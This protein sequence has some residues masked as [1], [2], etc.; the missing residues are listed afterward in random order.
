MQRESVWA[1]SH[2]A[3]EVR[4]Q[5]CGDIAVVCLKCSRLVFDSQLLQKYQMMPDCARHGG[6][7]PVGDSKLFGGLLHDAGQRSI[8]GVAD[9]RAQMMD[10]VMV[11]TAREP[12][13][14]RIRRRV[15]GC[16]REDVI[17]AVV[18]VAA[19]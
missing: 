15:I 12:A 4:A 8:V 10:D 16:G 18:E 2:L 6:M 13:H 3:P 9:K 19:A 11:E 7:L 5:N 1:R 17:D 14:D